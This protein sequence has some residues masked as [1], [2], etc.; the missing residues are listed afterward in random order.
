VLGVLPVFWL[1]R[2]AGASEGWTT[3][4]TFAA[5]F[6]SPIW[7]FSNIPYNVVG[8][9]L[10]VSVAVSL[11]LWFERPRR[12]PDVCRRSFVAA[13][14]GTVP[15]FGIVIRPF[16]ASALPAFAGWFLWSV[17]R[18]PLSAAARGRIITILAVVVLA[19][20]SAL[21]LLDFYLF[22]S[23]MATAYHDLSHVMTFDSPARA[24][25]RR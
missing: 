5:A 21:A 9:M 19:G 22:G 24:R 14:L 4:L 13:A 11:C 15:T 3:L 7:M 2:L 16:F 18:S 20:C 1:C 10:V 23:P 8:E 25:G 6:S 17:W 12:E